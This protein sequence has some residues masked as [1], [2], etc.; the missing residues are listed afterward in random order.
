[1]ASGYSLDTPSSHLRTLIPHPL[2]KG[3]MQAHELSKVPG[4]LVLTPIAPSP[5]PA[6]S[7]APINL[8]SPAIMAETVGKKKGKK[9]AS[10]AKVTTKV[11]AA[12]GPPNPPLGPKA[13]LAQLQAQNPPPPPWP[14]LVLSLMHHTLVSTLC[15]TA[16]LAPLVLVNTC[17]ATLSTDPTHANVWVSAAKWTPKGNLVVFTGPGISHDALFATSHILTSAISQAL[18]DDLRIS[19]HLNVKW[20]KVMVNS[21]PT[22]ISE[23]CPTAHFPATCW[24]SLINNNPSLHHLKVCQLPSW[25]RRPSL[26]QLGSQSSLVLTF[27]DPDGSLTP[28]LIYARNVY[29]FGSQC[30]VLCWYN[31]PPSPAKCEVADFA[32]KVQNTQS[33]YESVA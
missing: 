5:L 22:G 9:W 21:I 18:P 17:N 31:P 20:G 33:V 24:Q 30:H 29:A 4:V 2:E 26:F 16:A 25:V 1:M 23:G 13:A 15:A 7:P 11:K 19:S 32:K 28:S 6:P 27:E 3:K 14:S 12:P 8:V 10:F